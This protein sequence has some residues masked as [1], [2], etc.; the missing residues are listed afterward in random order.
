MLLQNRLE[1][2]LPQGFQFTDE[3]FLEFCEINR[4][5]QIE[6]TKEQKIIIMTPTNSETGGKSGKVFGY[7]FIWN[8]QNQYG[9]TFDS[10]TGFT[11]PDGS[12]FSPDASII[13][14]DRWN[15]LTKDQKR[16]FSPICPEFIVELK[17]PSDSLSVLQTKM[18]NWLANGV[19]LGWLI[20][21]DAEQVYIYRPGKAV[22]KVSNFD[23]KLSGEAILQGF[24]L[25]LTILR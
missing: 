12:V 21:P 13:A 1:L 18:Q 22:E 15:R 10:S 25:D 20:D 24:E 7:L 19:Q 11:L 4:D 14:F 23:G 3:A 8:L 5:I 6:R 16:K 2:I 9:E 17:S